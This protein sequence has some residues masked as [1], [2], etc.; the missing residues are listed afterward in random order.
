V[1]R[2]IPSVRAALAS[3]P[4][5][6]E[7][8]DVASALVLSGLAV[9]GFGTVFNGPNYLVAS[10]AGAVAGAAVGLVAA[11][12]RWPAVVTWAAA[13]VGYFAVGAPLA[14]R[15]LAPTA[16]GDLLDGTVNGWAR[17][18]T[19]V[20]PAGR[21]GNLLAPPVLCAYAAA[22]SSVV[23]ARRFPRLPVCVLP[24]L[25]ALAV[26]VLFGL[27]RP[28]SLLLQGAAF[29]VATIAWLSVRD[30]RQRPVV[31]HTTSTRRRIGPVVLLGVAGA[32]AFVVG[33]NLPLADSRPRFVL[34]EEV[35]PPFDP[36]TY[37][38]PLV[39]YRTFRTESAKKA[40]YLTAEGLPEGGRIRV[41]V[42]DDY[43]GT[44]WRATGTGGPAS[45][46]Y[47]RVGEVIPQDVEGRRVDVALEVGRLGGVWVPGV[48]EPTALDF[49][50]P[51]RGALTEAFRFNRQADVG[52][53]PGVALAAGDRVL[54]G[55]V[56]R[57]EPAPAV[58]S[59]AAVDRRASVPPPDGL[60]ERIRA[61]AAEKAAGASGPFAQ[62][63]AL[64]SWLREGYYSD[65]GR[66]S[67]VP[68]GHSLGRLARL[69]DPDRPM[70]GNAEQYAAAMAVLARSI[71]L[72]T[73]V[74][75]G[76]AAEGHDGRGTVVLTGTHAK[77]WVEI[78]FAGHGWVPFDPTPD[79]ARTP[80][81]DPPPTPTPR[82]VESQQ[83]PPPTPPVLA[84][85]DDRER[86]VEDPDG[87]AGA[88]SGF[89]FGMVIRVVATV[90]LPVLV[91]A[92]PFAL[93]AG[94]KA[95]RRRR[96]RSTGP[97]ET[98]ISAGWR[99]LVDVARDLGHGVPPRS[100]RREAAGAIAGSGLDAFAPLA[101]E[102]DA[103]VFAREAPTADAAAAFWASV[104]AAIDAVHSPLRRR[105]RIRASVSLAS[106]R[107]AR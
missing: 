32:G 74:V 6:D 27:D 82:V 64:A 55:A 99:E 65:G 92:L 47:D 67:D 54:L 5:F 57:P 107:A 59:K 52:A 19:T 35:K 31:V 84:E 44:V 73:R 89:P 15:S 71:G 22:L 93:V 58:L 36:R 38:S 56:V 43:D 69:L 66:G 100:T 76:F 45:G 62:A 39:A 87:A 13:I 94:I 29:A 23:L 96:R 104:D 77:A 79:E 46:V 105:D 10:L 20:P 95:R 106:L 50:G 26:A 72:P 12:L 37:P 48:G 1:N 41:A 14:V 3:R 85:V 80:Q 70:V 28:A 83:A 34:R 103:A 102:A 86:A 2:G 33:P 101:V 18:L 60:D 25:A 68:P 78:G 81:D 30:A 49:G 75:L 16:V 42:L 8:V 7:V 88:A 40:T 90:A 97:P 98:R 21:E 17:L 61:L 11:R 51:R 63:T 24:P 9:V 91:L 4:A 53:V